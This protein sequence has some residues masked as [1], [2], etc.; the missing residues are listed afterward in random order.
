MF[1]FQISKS[2]VIFPGLRL[3][4]VQSSKWLLSNFNVLMTLSLRAQFAFEHVPIN[5][6]HG[7][8]TPSDAQKELKFFFPEEHT[9]ALIKPDATTHKGKAFRKYGLYLVMQSF[10]QR[11]SNAHCSKSHQM[12]SPDSLKYI[13]CA[14]KSF[15]MACIIQIEISN[16]TFLLLKLPT[17]LSSLE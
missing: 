2:T 10:L 13:F 4:I 15:Y 11:I 8:S 17:G 1:I 14:E 7:S 12:H 5:Q 3:I 9:F 6:L 16:V